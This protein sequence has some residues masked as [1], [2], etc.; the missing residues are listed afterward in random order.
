MP[1]LKTG[2]YY[3][4][5]LTKCLVNDKIYVGKRTC[6]WLPETDISY[7]GSGVAFS[8][9]VKKYG[10]EN[11]IKQ[12]IE[13]CIDSAHLNRREKYWIAYY[14]S[15]LKGYNLTPGGEED[16]TSIKNH[17][18]KKQI[19]KKRSETWK[20]N[21]NNDIERQNK[22]KK[23]L[24]I[25]RGL[26]N[27]KTGQG[28]SKKVVELKID[29]NEVI[30]EYES[31][32]QCELKNDIVGVYSSIH[33]NGLCGGRR[34]LF[35]RADGLYIPYVKKQPWNTGI[36]TSV[37]SSTQFKK[38]HSAWNKDKKGIHL[39]P[40]SEWK[41]GR[42][43]WNKG[44]TK[45]KSIEVI[46]ELP[47]YVYNIEVE[48]NHNYFVNGILTHNC[49]DPQNP[50]KASS[51]VERLNTIEFYDHTL[52][53]R[54]NQLE[55]GVRIVV[56]QRLHEQDLTGHLMDVKD[57]RPEEHKHICIPG[58]LDE[59]ILS[60]PDIKKYYKDGLFWPTRFSRS[61]ID[62]FKKSLGSLQ[63]AGQ[64]GQ[65][66]VPPE[67]NLFKKAWFEVIDP[68]MIVRD[69]SKSPIY[70][71]IDTAF[72]E[73][74]KE[75]ND[76][77]G[78][79]TVFEKNDDIYIVNFTQVWMEMPE[80]IKFIPQYVAMNGYTSYS[81]IYIEPKANGKSVVQ[82]IKRETALNVIEIEAEFI[83]DDKLT[84]AS[85]VSPTAQAGRVKMIKG[86]WNDK[87]LS[88]LTSFPNARHDEAV[89]TTVYALN[90]Y[91]PSNN[92]LSAF[93]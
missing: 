23:Q 11:F 2:T 63:Y 21:Y 44:L 20:A 19:L 1:R 86:V 78:L 27:I 70:F 17:P 92:F 62:S 15:E 35:L 9:A 64:I 66:P 5:Y 7:I 12:I 30:G 76:P 13:N 55:I 61:V 59:E 51:E 42:E 60:P 74:E 50:K 89:D 47:D 81:A 90:H 88:E 52:V 41:K 40:N 87:Y 84:R 72:T 34:F 49:D 57:G 69:P 18:N 25:A 43:P 83:R 8:H 10:K 73:D 54:L 53:S 16:N 48:D 45:I 67:G 28:R 85:S 32:R 46:D 36:K 4:V 65:R 56:Q 6:N 38:G 77:T 26:R 22:R 58:E 24:N 91:F 31:I 33:R 14:K 29:S 3:Y 39:S 80:L 71:F 93:I 79:L 75:R 82:T 68:A 37:K